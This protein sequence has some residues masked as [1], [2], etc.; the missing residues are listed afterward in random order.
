MAR[1]TVPLEALVYGGRYQP[2][3]RQ[4][5][6]T[7]FHDGLNERFRVM[8]VGGVEV[9]W[10]QTYRNGGQDAN[11]RFVLGDHVYLIKPQVLGR[12]WIRGSTRSVRS[13]GWIR[14]VIHPLD[15]NRAPGAERAQWW[16]RDPVGFVFGDV[17]SSRF[18]NR[19][20]IRRAA[21]FI[22]DG[23]EQC[24]YRPPEMTAEDYHAN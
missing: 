22:I 16:I 7:V 15:Y 11:A 10:K 4:Y 12:K 17:A 23:P 19:R 9:L 20:V 21:E 3:K 6:A 14:F 18:P 5:R 1:H 2:S 13:K 8:T 24:D